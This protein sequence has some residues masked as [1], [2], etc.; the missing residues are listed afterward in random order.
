MA[1]YDVVVV[2]AGPA[3][4]MAARYAA[5]AGLSVLLLDKSL[6]IGTPK[7][8]GEGL[9]I[10]AFRE[11]SIPA[12]PRFIN[13]E[14]YGFA[15]YAPDG[16]PVKARFSEVM[17][18][19]IERKMFDKHLAAEAARAGAHV[20]AGAYARL[21]LES[22][23]P[24]GVKVRRHDGREAEVRCKVVVAADGVES[25]IAR[26]AGLDTRLKPSDLDSCFEY[27]MAGI[28]IEDPDL[29]HMYM[30]NKIAPRG[31]IW[32]FP[33]DEDRANV[34]I[35]I[36]GHLEEQAK[37]L[38]DKFIQSRPELRRGSILEVNVGCVPVGGFLKQLVKDNLLV[39]GD[40]A[41]QVN[42][43]HGGGVYEAMT[44]G[45]LAGQAIA[46]ALHEGDLRLLREYE[47]MWWSTHGK[48]LER[49]LK[50][51]RFAEKLSDDEMNYLA[52]VW[53][54]DDLVELSRGNYRV[55]AGKIVAHPKLLAL[56][57]KLL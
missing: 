53:R 51:R 44:A 24:A 48:R 38:L 21:K 47:S 3:G 52:R 35:G 45:K 36:G 54:G 11:L 16:T 25:Q 20:E 50:V 6:E 9:G 34:G 7:R 17:G 28:S 40:A 27:E 30:G 41:R 8:C 14:I 1:D 49:I 56:V 2:G 33:K 22:G 31:Y 5:E 10:R 32:V 4:S 43:L 57:R 42:P 26:Q 12:D 15:V 23:R 39:V 18:Y 19:I 29:I 46:K 13:R 55:A 37:L